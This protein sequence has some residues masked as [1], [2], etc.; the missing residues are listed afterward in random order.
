MVHSWQVVSLPLPYHTTVFPLRFQRQYEK[1][2][3]ERERRRS[4]PSMMNSESGSD[5]GPPEA[6]PLPEDPQMVYTEHSRSNTVPTLLHMVEFT[7]PEFPDDSEQLQLAIHKDIYAVCNCHP[8]LDHETETVMLYPSNNIP[9]LADNEHFL[10]GPGSN[11]ALTS[12][13]IL[14]AR[15]CPDDWTAPLRTFLGIQHP[16]VSGLEEMTEIPALLTEQVIKQRQRFNPRLSPSIKRATAPL[17]D[18]FIPGDDDFLGEFEIPMAS[19]QV[20]TD[21]EPDYRR[22]RGKLHLP[23]MVSPPFIPQPIPPRTPRNP[24]PHT[25][26]AASG[27]VSADIPNYSSTTQSKSLP[28]DLL[29]EHEYL[30]LSTDIPQD[31]WK[32]YGLDVVDTHHTF[33]VPRALMRGEI[34]ILTIHHNLGQ[35][36]TAS[37]TTIEDTLSMALEGWSYPNL[38]YLEAMQMIRSLDFP[39]ILGRELDM[40]AIAWKETKGYEL[41]FN[42]ASAHKE[43]SLKFSSEADFFRQSQAARYIQENA[44]S[45]DRPLKEVSIAALER[46]VLECAKYALSQGMHYRIFNIIYGNSANLAPHTETVRRAAAQ[47]P[48]Y[49]PFLEKMGFFWIHALKSTCKPEH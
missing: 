41:M 20:Q 1:L 11:V 23:G 13:G 35:N 37:P 16:I 36:L 26:G 48:K 4:P 33:K 7:G 42:Q 15:P 28:W 12:A 14:Y 21:P 38:S 40:C 43:V 27:I 19:T 45:L 10:G 5:E 8:S 31:Q 32:I 9:L 22:G 34:R 6:R 47:Y 2:K 46:H 18:R 24:F 29:P 3:R 49:R 44:P 25:V 30:H 17:E 39:H